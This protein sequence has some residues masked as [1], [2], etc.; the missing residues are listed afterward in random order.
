[1][2]HAVLILMFGGIFFV[3]F[4]RLASAARRI[5]AKDTSEYGWLEN[6][7][8]T[9]RPVSLILAICLLMLAGGA[10]YIVSTTS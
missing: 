4:G 3:I 7:I 10:I 1:M 2:I 9:N 8:L 6:T 5:N